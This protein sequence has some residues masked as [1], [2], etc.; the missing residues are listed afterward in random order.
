MLFYIILFS[1]NDYILCFSMPIH[2]NKNTFVSGKMQ[3]SLPEFLKEFDL[4]IRLFP[5][6]ATN[7]EF[8]PPLEWRNC[9]GILEDLVPIGIIPIKSF[10]TH[11]FMGNFS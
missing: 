11:D 2:M 9:G 3:K 4:P 10:G 7:Y 1:K 8:R 5:Q 6:D